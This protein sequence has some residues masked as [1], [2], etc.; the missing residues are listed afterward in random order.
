MLHPFA[1]NS[2]AGPF[3]IAA[4]RYRVGSVPAIPGAVWAGV[5]FF[6]LLLSFCLLQF[7][8]QFLESF[9]QDLS[10]LFCLSISIQHLTHFTLSAIFPGLRGLCG[11]IAIRSVFQIELLQ[12]LLRS[13]LSF[14]ATLA[15]TLLLL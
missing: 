12:L 14:A 10:P 11:I 5:K 1:Q 7:R 6:F 4:H 9:I 13:R 2:A 15:L 3:A 8:L